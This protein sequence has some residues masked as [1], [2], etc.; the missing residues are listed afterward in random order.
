MC[1]AMELAR[2]QPSAIPAI[3]RALAAHL[4]ATQALERS[5][6]TLALRGGYVLI[7]APSDSPSPGS[8]ADTEGLASP[9]PW[10]A[11]TPTPTVVNE[12]RVRCVSSFAKCIMADPW[13][14][15]W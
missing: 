7:D 10:A 1:T 8:R 12:V 3:N 11:S 13:W 4:D 5:R 14:V 9:S 6:M 2:R 15:P